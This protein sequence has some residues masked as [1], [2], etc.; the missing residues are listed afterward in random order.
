[1]DGVSGPDR[2][3]GCF[4]TNVIDELGLFA[5]GAE[6]AI[7]GAQTDLRLP[8]D[9]PHGLGQPFEPRSQ[10]LADPRGIAIGPRRLDQRPTR[11]PAI[12]A[13]RG[14]K[15]ARSECAS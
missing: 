15:E 3:C 7:A 6:A 4:A 13:R 2:P 11:A 10:C 8:R 5:R 9:V 1:M 14:L 12:A